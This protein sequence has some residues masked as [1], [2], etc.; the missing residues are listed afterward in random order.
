MFRRNR[1]RPTGLQP[2]RWMLVLLAVLVLALEMGDYQHSRTLDTGSSE[3]SM[4]YELNDPEEL[5]TQ[6]LLVEAQIAIPSPVYVPNSV[7]RPLTPDIDV[8]SPPPRRG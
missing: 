8:E 2:L 5:P 6:P 1:P 3:I 7:V 4:A